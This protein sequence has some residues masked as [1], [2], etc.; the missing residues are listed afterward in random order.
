MIKDFLILN[1]IG[2]ENQIGDEFACAGY[3]ERED[4]IS[5]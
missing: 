1:F 4:I 3:N 2:K 5:Y